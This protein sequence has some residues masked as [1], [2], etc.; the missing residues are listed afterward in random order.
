M[1]GRPVSRLEISVVLKEWIVIEGI[2]MAENMKA[3]MVLT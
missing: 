1:G 2:T 3:L